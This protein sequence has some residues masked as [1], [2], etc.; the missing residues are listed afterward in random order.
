MLKTGNQRDQSEVKSSAF[1]MNS[2]SIT[3]QIKQFKWKISNTGGIVSLKG[4]K[5]T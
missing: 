3:V 4:A 1:Q 5:L 2:E